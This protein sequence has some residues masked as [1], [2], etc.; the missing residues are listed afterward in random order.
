MGWSR[1]V[2]RV[3]SRGL[4][5]RWARSGRVK[6]IAAVFGGGCC[7]GL[8]R[9]E[10]TEAWP[11]RPDGF[12]WA[13]FLVNTV[14]AFA[15]ALLLVLVIEVL[16]PTTYLRPALGTG[17]L[18]AWTT[19]S[20]LTTGVAELVAHRQLATAGSYLGATVLAGLAAAASGLVL[21][22]SISAYRRRSPPSGAA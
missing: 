12:P 3:A 15:L 9:Y 4:A 13:T 14:G 10:V 6:Q 7:G 17:F 11:T 1:R 18:G 16:R 2:R 19:F 21:G 20:A 8:A 5:A 22:R